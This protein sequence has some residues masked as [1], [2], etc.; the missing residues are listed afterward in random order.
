MSLKLYFAHGSP[1]SRGVLLLIR[2]LKLDVDLKVIDLGAGDQYN[3]DFLK[4]NPR[5]QVPVLVDGDFVLTESRAMMAY[6]V[7]KHDQNSSLY[8]SDI[9]KRAKIDECLY[10]DATVL[11]PSVSQIIVSLS[12]LAQQVSLIFCL[13][14]A[15]GFVRESHKD[16]GEAAREFDQHVECIGR[17]SRPK[18]VVCRQGN[19]NR[20][21]FD[22]SNNNNR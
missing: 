18:Q 10:Y 13:F 14:L 15:H 20:R 5:H 3:E 21:Y 7:A 22:C 4:L 8:P 1:P 16:S 9:A 19:D 11:F 6:L 2:K 12:A 17:I